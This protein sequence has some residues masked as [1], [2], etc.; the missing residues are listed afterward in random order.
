MKCD[1]IKEKRS[2]IKYQRNGNVGIGMDS[3][4]HVE[5]L[6]SWSTR[7]DERREKDDDDGY[8]KKFREFYILT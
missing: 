2:E 3:C 1:K 6:L 7:S 5:Y 4:L 8:E